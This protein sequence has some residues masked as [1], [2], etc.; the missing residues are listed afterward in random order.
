MTK[1]EKAIKEASERASAY[2][3]DRSKY[4]IL[5]SGRY[6]SEKK[7]QSATKPTSIKKS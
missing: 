1:A 4:P 3:Y 6:D 5:A 2:R 7:A